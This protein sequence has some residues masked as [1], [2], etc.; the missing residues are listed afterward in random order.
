M[1]ASKKGKGGC[2]FLA[3]DLN[4]ILLA[5]VLRKV[6]G[7]IALLPCISLHFYDKCANCDKKNCVLHRVMCDVRDANLAILKKENCS[8]YFRCINMCMLSSPH[9]KI[10]NQ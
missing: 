10:F 6:D 9:D 4:E 8:R 3:K 2:Y 5:D 1:L 7:P